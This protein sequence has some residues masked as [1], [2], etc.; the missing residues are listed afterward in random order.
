MTLN[1]FYSSLQKFSTLK[2]APLRENHELRYC[3]INASDFGSEIKVIIGRINKELKKLGKIEKITF[4]LLKE[5]KED[6]SAIKLAIKIIKLIV[7]LR[8]D[9]KDFFIHTRIF[10]DILCRIIKIQ[11]GKK[12]EQ[13]P[14]SMTALLK[15]KEVLKID[16]KFFKELRNKMIWYND[17]VEKGRDRIVHKLG[18]LVFTNTKEGKLGFDIPNHFTL[19]WG[20][21]TVKPIED[22]IE[23][24]IK[25]LSE[26]VDYLIANLKLDAQQPK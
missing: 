14:Q 15:S 22:Y 16:E 10:L 11:Y 4:S 13:L 24:T 8:L 6:K 9:I 19:S 21:Q 5:N 18:N 23:N 26:M 17:F 1:K 25:N 3:Y 12:G 2:K 20:T 7:E